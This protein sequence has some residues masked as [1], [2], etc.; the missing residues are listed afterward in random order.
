[1]RSLTSSPLA[2]R[3]SAVGLA[4]LLAA[5]SGGDDGADAGP[6]DSGV[7][8]DSGADI[9][10]GP[11]DTGVQGPCDPIS[12]GG[13][14]NP[15]QSCVLQI[16]DDDGQCRELINAVGHEEVCNQSLQNCEAGFACLFLQGDDDPTCRKV[17]DVRSGDGCDGVQ[18]SAAAY[19]CTI[20]LQGI[21]QYGFC[22][23]AA[24]ACDPLNSTCGMGENCGFVD[25]NGNTGC[26]PAGSSPLGGN[27]SMDACRAPGMCVTLTN[28]NM[29]PTC[30]EPC[31]LM[32][33]VCSQP[34]HDCGDIGAPFGL[35]VP[36]Q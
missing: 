22:G 13:C 35:C 19:A 12:G 10:A 23:E 24:E 1:M 32:N 17:C 34:N 33:P 6:M 29:N 4:G 20:R 15:A 25:D 30:Y 3:L 21:R 8:P 26:I 27:C 11:A 14:L 16:D 5:C 28:V 9:D 31:D 2:L 18:G 36:M 7:A